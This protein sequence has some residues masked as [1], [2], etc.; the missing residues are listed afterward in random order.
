MQAKS[1]IGELLRAFTRPLSVTAFVICVLLTNLGVLFAEQEETG[2]SIGKVSIA[3]NLIV[4]ELNE[5]VLGKTNLFDLAGRT[6]R[7]T[8]EGSHY[9]VENR[10]LQWD[11]EFGPELPGAQVKLSKFSFPFSKKRWDSFLVGITGSVRFGVSEEDIGADP[12]GHPDGGITLDRFDQLSE[13]AGKLSDKAPAIC[14]FLKPRM[15]GPHYVKELS[16]RVVI[17]WNLSEPY[18]GL[19]DFS[20]YRTVDRFQLVLHRD[21][22]IDMSYK[23]VAAK[24]AIVGVYPVLANGE[25]PKPVHFSAL[26]NTH[27]GFASLYEAFHYLAPPRP[28]DLSCTVI[29]AQGDNFDFLAYY[30]DFRVDKQEASPPSDGPV[31]GKVTGIG[32]TQHDQTPQVLASPCTPGRFQLGFE[33]PVWVGANEMQAGPPEVAL[34][35]SPHDITFYRRQLREASPDGMPVAYNY[36][37]GHLGHEVGHRWGAYASAKVKG[38]T[39]SLGPWPH[40]DRGLHA[41]VAYPYSLPTE[42]STL[43]G[44]VWQ[45]NFDGTYTQLRD[46][47]FV[48]ASGY[49]YLDLYLMGLVSAAEVPD[50]FMLKNLVTLAIEANGRRIF[51]AERVKVSVQDVIAAE[52]PRSPD[53]DHSQRKFNTGIVVMV[54]HGKTPSPEL[55]ERANGIRRQWITYWETATGHRALMRATGKNP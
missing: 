4:V 8:P 51:K 25:R 44:G 40:W 9:R 38:E 2:H 34:V 21:G 3:G 12:Y 14:V 30:S 32:N 27:R 47:Y 10:T 50:F 28:Q 45:D 31:G 15:S 6:L 53:V 7:F 18:G 1:M 35:G 36:A 33:Q 16:D 24:D 22:S 29:Q 11:P 54:E 17:T 41:P 46:G 5:G 52:G 23:E 39:M 48:P 13:V 20:W 26:K 43:G 55:L 37:V 19:L 49:S 42:A